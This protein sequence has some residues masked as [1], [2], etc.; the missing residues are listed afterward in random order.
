MTINNNTNKF[1]RLLKPLEKKSLLNALP[2]YKPGYNEYRIKINDL[3]VIGEGRFGNGSLILGNNDSKIDLGVSSAPV[4]AF[5]DSMYEGFNVYSVIH[6]EMDGMIEIDIK[7]SEQVI[8]DEI[9]L[10]EIKTYSNWLPGMKDPF[11]DSFIREVEVRGKELVLAISANQK[12]IWLFNS[13]S[14]VN[15]FIPV[16]NFYV[17]VMRVMNIK[18]PQIALN[19]NRLFQKLDEF[20]DEDL[21]NG[22][23]NYNKSWRK[24][25]VKNLVDGIESRMEIKKTFFNFWKK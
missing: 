23:I 19:P 4:F 21:K 12:R 17:D 24:I 14:G 15:Y 7:H 2:E 6:E 9:V 1:P 11:D 8:S 5:A 22:F 16:S 25:V 18:D 20:K 13:E 3:S 10:K